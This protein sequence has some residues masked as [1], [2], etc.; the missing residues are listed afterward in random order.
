MFFAADS[1]KMSLEAPLSTIHSMC[2]L[3][4]PVV[5]SRAFSIGN[6]KK[7]GTAMDG[8]SMRHLARLPAEDFNELAKLINAIFPQDCPYRKHGHMLGQD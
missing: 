8:W 3:L 4:C 6:K 7:S 1:D 2:L 5:E